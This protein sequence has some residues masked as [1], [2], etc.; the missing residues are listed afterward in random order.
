MNC[1]DIKDLYYG[2]LSEP[3]RQSIKQHLEACESCRVE[4]ERLSRVVNYLRNAPD[5]E[6]ITR[7]RFVSDK[8]FEPTLWRRLSARIA[9]SLAWQAALSLPLWIAFGLL[10]SG[11]LATEYQASP[12]V[13][14]AVSQQETEARIQKLVDGRVASAVETAVAQVEARNEE[15][16]RT[17][18]AAFRSQYNRDREQFH[19][20]AYSFYRNLDQKVNRVA[21]ASMA[22]Y[23]GAGEPVLNTQ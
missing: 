7:I 10:L 20:A 2:E 17:Q 9:P 16:T 21:L 3:E 11:R 13:R 4:A 12:E 14:P 6:P 23:P 5:Q 8:V 1:P 18:M 15:Q 22:K 19:E